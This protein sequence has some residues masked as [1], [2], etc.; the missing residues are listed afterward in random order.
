MLCRVKKN[1]S[2]PEVAE[3]EHTKYIKHLKNR[4]YSD[5]VIQEALDKLS[6]KSREELYEKKE[7]EK[8]SSESA[9]KEVDPTI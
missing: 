5:E 9:K 8:I 4:N 3:E 1:C 6:S 7:E 2:E